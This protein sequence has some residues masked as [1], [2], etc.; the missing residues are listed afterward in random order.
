MSWGRVVV[1]DPELDT[2]I[3]EL[4]IVEL[5]LIIRH[6]GPRDPKTA[7]YRMPD[8]VMY[9]LLC[10]CHQGFGLSPFGKI[11]HGYNDKF[12]LAPSNG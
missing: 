6:E 9:L 11:V 5:F 12:A 8:E 4:R 1:L 3:P 10:D 2:E 7:Y